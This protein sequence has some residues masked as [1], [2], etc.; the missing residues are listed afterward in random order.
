MRPSAGKLPIREVRQRTSAASAATL[1]FPS[2]SGSPKKGPWGQNP[3]S[4]RALSGGKIAKVC[5][6]RTVSLRQWIVS[7]SHRVSPAESVEVVV[8]SVYVHRQT[9]ISRSVS[10]GAENRMPKLRWPA[11]SGPT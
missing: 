10:F 11:C 7:F 6:A 8:S 4:G 3:T 2:P 1:K 5:A 9:L